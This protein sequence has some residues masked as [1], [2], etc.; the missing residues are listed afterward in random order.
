M[1]A[2]TLKGHLD[3]LIL[4]TAR[5][6]DA[7]IERCVAD[8]LMYADGKP[9]V[10]ITDMSLRMTGLSREKVEET[11]ACVQSPHAAAGEV[12]AR[13]GR[14]DAPVASRLQVRARAR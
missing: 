13:D 6:K 9:I 2:E 8:A 3:G 4:A 11:W 7:I 5:R 12:A 1:R 14:L 10:E